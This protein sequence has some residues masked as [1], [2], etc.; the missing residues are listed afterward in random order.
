MK[1]VCLSDTHKQHRQVQVPAGDVLIHA[2]DICHKGKDEQVIQDFNQW[3]GE[4]PHRYK[5]VIAGNHDRPF[6]RAPERIQKMITHAIYLEDSGVE[7]N[8]VKFWG[9]PVTPRFFNM[10][11][12]R[13]RGAS[14]RQHW[15]MIPFGTDILITHTPPRGRLDKTFIGLRAGCRDLRRAIEEVQP[16]L[17][18]FGHIHEAHGYQ[19][20]DTTRFYNVSTV[21]ARFN[22]VNQPVVIEFA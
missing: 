3:L 5:I 21:N 16:R 14:I 20:V 2:G 1:L 18:I 12:N 7:I 9:S 13:A 10:A 19:Q 17:H 15:N 22:V 11:F 4:L 6:E 8:G